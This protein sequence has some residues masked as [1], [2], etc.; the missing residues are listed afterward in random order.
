MKPFALPAR[1]VH[2]DFHTSPFIPDVGCEFDATAFAETFRRA[3]VES[4]SIFAKCHHGMSY[5]PT[6]TGTQHPALK[7]RDLL[8]E[9]IEA[10]HRAGIRCP[11]YTTVVWEED[12][13]QKHPEWRQ[14][15]KAGRFAGWD[16]SANQKDVQ[17]GMWK[18]NNF[19]DP[20]YQDYIEAHVRE[21]FARYGDAVDGLFFDILFFAPNACW[22]PA[23]VAFRQKHGLLA[24]APA[25][26]QRFEALAQATFTE[27]FTRITQ[28]LSTRASIFYN[29]NNELSMD[30]AI[31]PR[32]RAPHMS[33]L[34]IESLP[35]GFWGYYHFP[36]L[37]RCLSR[38]GKPWLAQTGR[39][40]KMWGDFGGIKRSPPSNTN[41]SARRP[42]A[43][44]TSSATNSPRAARPTPEPTNSSAPSMRNAPPPTRSTPVRSRSRKSACS[45]RTGPA[46]TPPPPAK[47]RKPPSACAMN[48]T[49]IAPCST[50]CP[51]RSPASTCSSCPTP[52]SSLPSSGKNSPPTT[53]P[54]AS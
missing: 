3:H 40:Q 7:G 37:A 41:A 35:S 22:S 28:S 5:Y 1:H 21:L 31:G 42:S 16:T 14:L 36:R 29:A 47:A 11:L 17:P 4:V 33:H 8:G 26:F 54:A 32:V 25:T 24:D 27:K 30:A 2:L 6:A 10:L 9:Q 51:A 13:A 45:A 39:F 52:P 23:S 53:P 19:L 12:V 18:F 44:A 46:S 48:S 20:D 38:W 15:D 34:E 43:A 49:T 50:P